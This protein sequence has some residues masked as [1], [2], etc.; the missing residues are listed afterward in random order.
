MIH[1]WNLKNASLFLTRHYCHRFTADIQNMYS[2]IVHI[3][4]KL[5]IGFVILAISI[6]ANLGDLNSFTYC[7][8]EGWLLR[9]GCYCL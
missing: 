8:S 4:I 6:E 5:P 7:L 2:S 1:D 9:P 3:A